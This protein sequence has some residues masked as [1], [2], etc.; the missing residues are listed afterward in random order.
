MKREVSPW[1]MEDQTHGYIYETASPAEL[2]AAGYRGQ[3]I[4]RRGDDAETTRRR[5]IRHGQFP[6]KP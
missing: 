1:T 6:Q 2:G 3:V 4:V 5:A